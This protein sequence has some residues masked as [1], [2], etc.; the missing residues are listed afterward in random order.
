[1]CTLVCV[2]PSAAGAARAVPAIDRLD[3]VDVVAGAVGLSSG[4]VAIVGQ[5]ADFRIGRWV[6]GEDLSLRPIGKTVKPALPN[7]LGDIDNMVATPSGRFIALPTS[8]GQARVI[9][10]AAGSTDEFVLRGPRENTPVRLFPGD[11]DG[12]VAV[13]QRGLQILDAE[14][15][16]STPARFSGPRPFTASRGRELVSYGRSQDASVFGLCGR[17]SRLGAQSGGVVLGAMDMGAST[18][19]TRLLRA[20]ALVAGSCAVSRSRTVATTLSNPDIR[21]QS[22][23][24]RLAV[25]RSGRIR[26]FKIG[27]GRYQDVVSISPDGRRVV[28]ASSSATR[29]VDTV[30]GTVRRLEGVR[31]AVPEDAFSAPAEGNPVALWTDDSA[32]LLIVAKNH[33][34]LW[35]VAAKGNAKRIYVGT[36]NLVRLSPDGSRVVLAASDGGQDPLLV[37]RPVTGGAPVALTGNVVFGEPIPSLSGTSWWLLERASE[38][39]PNGLQRFDSAD[40]WRAPWEQAAVPF[41]PR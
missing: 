8:G 5:S 2:A 15:R 18:M 36:T 30:T 20:S 28:L 16:T 24:V 11:P 31:V 6:V 14:R 4:G 35:S 32:R 21:I 7:R 1:M 22:N 40:I 25:L 39:R 23:S 27:G 41:S 10:T 19:S 29:I 38:R 17:T 26:S 9:P 12:F 13:S 33:G 37:T 34:G 3:T